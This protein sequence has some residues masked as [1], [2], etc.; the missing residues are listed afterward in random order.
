[1]AGLVE[2]QINDR[3]GNA[4]IRRVRIHRTD[5]GAVVGEGLSNGQSGL[6]GIDVSYTGDAYAVILDDVAGVIEKYQIARMVV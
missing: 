5:T 2:I 6:C 1:M 4:A 3:D